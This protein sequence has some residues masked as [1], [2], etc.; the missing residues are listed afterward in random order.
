MF[1]VGFMACHLCECSGPSW[2]GARAYERADLRE[3]LK[4][5]SHGVVELRLAGHPGASCSNIS[6][7]LL[8]SVFRYRII[9]KA[10]VTYLDHATMRLFREDL[11]G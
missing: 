4:E 2:C 7:L 6:F 9:I 11:M 5:N 10:R 1:A 8:T 3:M